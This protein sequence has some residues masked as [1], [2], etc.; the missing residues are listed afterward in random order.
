MIWLAAGVLIWGLVHFVPSAAPALR[1]VLVGKLGENGYKALFGLSMIAAVLLMVFGWKST[2]ETVVYTP[3][4]WGGRLALV[5][6]VGT[7]MGFFAPYMPNNLVRLVRHPQL[8]GIV[9]FGV[10]HLAAVGHVR[11]LV[12]FGGLGLWAAIEIVL[13]NRRDGPRTRPE[14]TA[15]KNDLK[16]F[17]AGLGFF[18]LM[19]FTHRALFGVSALPT[20]A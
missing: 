6:M 20:G 5:A 17:L 18:L 15:H 8:T 13:I 2:A 9:L 10:G 11:S 14:K 4:E 3:P 12:L 16:L 7:A 19:L 1:K